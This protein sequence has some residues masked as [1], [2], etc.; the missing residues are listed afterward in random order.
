MFPF[1]TFPKI[2]RLKRELVITEKLDGT[3]ACVAWFPCITPEEKNFAANDPYCITLEELDGILHGL[4]A[5]S[6]SRWIAPEGTEG[7]AKG[8][9][10]FAFAQFVGNNVDELAKLGTGRHFGEWYGRGIQRNYGLENKRFALFNTARW[11]KHNPNT[12]ACCE[13]TT[14]IEGLVPDEA[15]EL[16]RTKGSQH[17]PGWPTP[18]G[19]VIY[20]SASRTLFKQTLEKDNEGKG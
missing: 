14:K 15:I 12:P 11:G 2:A 19:I 3:N 6:R 7:L 10:N 9:D 13:V 20:H 17:V 5:G 4:Y 1:E 16:L 18:E 8:C